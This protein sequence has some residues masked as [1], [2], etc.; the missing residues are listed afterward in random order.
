[1]KCN[2][3]LSSFLLLMLVTGCGGKSDD[4]S[5]AG[6][7]SIAVV[8]KGA[9]APN[10]TSIKTVIKA[11]SI[12]YSRIISG[13]AVEKW[14]KKI[15]PTELR[16]LQSRITAYSLLNAP[17][18]TPQA[19][20]VTCA[21]WGGM[22]ITMEKSDSAHTLDIDGS[23]CDRA[24]WPEG[25]RALV[26]LHDSLVAA[27]TCPTFSP[28]APDWCSDGTILPQVVDENGCYGP[29]RCQRDVACPDFVPHAPDW[30]ADG[31]IIPPQVDGNGCYGP[32]TCQRNP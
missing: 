19:G 20:Q 15:A 14:E 6:I 3:L 16:Y 5:D 8:D 29:P 30:C 17:D 26:D 31:T 23:V 18:V 25:I 9:V 1:M 21:G 11:D 22:T 10:S 2:K 4:R 12:E 27:N 13:Q 28:P 32:P 7:V 24:F